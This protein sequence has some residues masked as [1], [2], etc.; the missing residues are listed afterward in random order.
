MT[1]LLSPPGEKAWSKINRE[2]LEALESEKFLSVAV[3]S[4]DTDRTS[5]S[6]SEEL[7]YAIGATRHDGD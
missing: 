2:R 1:G 4:G 3:R 5:F 7:H 6:G